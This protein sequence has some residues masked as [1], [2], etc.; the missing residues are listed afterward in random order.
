MTDLSKKLEEAEAL[1]ER[2]K[3]Q[4]KQGSCQETGHDW[5]FLGGR[6]LGC[7]LEDDCNCSASVHIC[8]KCDD[9]DYGENEESAN[10]KEDCQIRKSYLE[11]LSMI[12]L[13]KNI[14]K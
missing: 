6:V 4:I 7:E 14:L 2:L 10:I 13:I 3:L 9:C 1:V 11:G 8:V 5:K 12:P